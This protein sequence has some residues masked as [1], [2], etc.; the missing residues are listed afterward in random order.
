MSLAL[1]N[2]GFA[3]GDIAFVDVVF[4]EV[5]LGPE[6]AIIDL[7]ALTPTFLPSLILEPAPAVIYLEVLP[8]PIRIDQ[9]FRTGDLGSSS[10]ALAAQASLSWVPQLVANSPWSGVA[11]ASPEPWVD[12]AAPSGA[13]SRA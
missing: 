6:A 11:G 10:W 7:Q 5:T 3:G 2:P 12:A 9:W 4:P 13:W 1:R 8:A